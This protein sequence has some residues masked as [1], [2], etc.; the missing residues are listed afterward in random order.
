MAALRAA[1]DTA[2]PVALLDKPIRLIAKDIEKIP[3]REKIGLIFS[4]GISPLPKKAT[5]SDL[6]KPEVL[7][8]LLAKMK[9]D[10]PV[11]Y[12]VF[13][14]SR[15]RY[16][17]RK[18]LAHKPESAVVV[19]GAAHVPGIMELAKKSEQKINLKVVEG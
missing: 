6:M 2:T 12:K 1:G 5:L 18:L 17:L 10:F 8:L 9:K 14:D 7:N 13:V 4:G 3:L 16:M 15:N 11:S 19:V